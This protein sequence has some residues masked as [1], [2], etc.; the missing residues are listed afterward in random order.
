[1]FKIGEFSKLTQ[2]SVRMLRYYDES[3]LMKPE[4]TDPNTGYR[5]YSANQIPELSKIVFLRDIGFNIAEISALLN[6]WNNDFILTRLKEKRRAVENE[7]NEEQNKLNKID[8]AERDILFGRDEIRYNIFIKS[9]PSCCVLSLRRIIGDYYKEEV[10]WKELCEF[11]DKNHISVCGEPFSI[12]HDIEYKEENVDAEVCIPINGILFDSKEGFAC[13]Y[14]E[15]VPY[16]AYTM[17]NGEFCNIKEAYFSFAEWLRENKKYK[18]SSPER[19]I[20]HRGPWNEKDSDH[21]LT[22]IQIPLKHR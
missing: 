16:M 22:E 4:Q 5:M 11:A 10:L 12:F 21:Y 19:Q 14:I 18:M 7:I 3:G 17:V 8:M 20:V 6:N 2:V 9:V 13:K 1:M 15:A